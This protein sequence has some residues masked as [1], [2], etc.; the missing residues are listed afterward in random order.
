[1]AVD[2]G[3]EHNEVEP[4]LRLLM[5]PSLPP[6]KTHNNDEYQ[7]ALRD[8]QRAMQTAVNAK[9]GTGASFQDREVALLDVADEACRVNLVTE[10]QGIADGLAPLLTVDGVEYARH[11]EGGA[12]YHSLCGS[13]HV[14]RAT[15]RRTG[16][17]NGATVVPMELLAGLV[18]GATPAL[19]FRVA[20]GYAQGPGRHAEKQ[21]HAD[22]RHPPSR[23]T[24]ERIGKAIGSE[25]RVAAPRIEPMVRQA[26]R[27]PM[28]AH[29]ISTGLD[30][31]SVPMEELRPENAPP[32][33]GRKERTKPYVRARPERINVNYRMAYV[34][35]VT[36]VDD[37]GEAL[38]TRR[39]GASGDEGAAGILQ[40]MMADVCSARKESNL[41]VGIMQDAA[42]ELWTLMRNAV[43][44]QAGVTHWHEGI[45]RYHLNERLGEIL[46]IIEPEECERRKQFSKWQSEME[47]DD[48]TIDRIRRWLSRQ[49]LSGMENRTA[50]ETEIL[51]G[52]STFLTNNKDRMGYASLRKEGMPCGSGVTE[53]ACK[54]LAMIRTKGCGQRWHEEGV[55]AALTLRALEMSDRL[56][57]F[58][59][60][61]A[62]DYV[63]D[64]RPIA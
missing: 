42:P 49:I 43:E 57:P 29:A 38:I 24:L 23:S 10:L 27:L 28:G 1:M 25:A 14:R 64:V 2:L 62:A 31:T 9:V 11:E 13:L 44:D 33:K 40:R 55:N 6:G 17:R 56:T 32:A 48:S 16:E 52:H 19:G 60:H 61:F 20:L 50:E 39:Y 41:P 36:I 54:S 8:V 51:E 12:D 37:D 22:H 58:W 30:R 46:R 21:M 53:G 34:G 18:E 3:M 7:V 35:T 45:D 5:A 47:V 63:A 15:Y 59:T 4:T 26:E